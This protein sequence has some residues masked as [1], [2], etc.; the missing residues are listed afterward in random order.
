VPFFIFGR[1]KYVRIQIGNQT[2]GRLP[3]VQNIPTAYTVLNKGPEHS[4][5]RQFGSFLLYGAVLLR[6]LPH[7]I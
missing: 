7:F 3:T 5:R 1:K 4:L 2:G 6:K